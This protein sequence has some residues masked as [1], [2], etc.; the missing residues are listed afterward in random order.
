VAEI[1]FLDSDS[2]FRAGFYAMIVLSP[3]CGQAFCPR[4]LE[5]RATV[6]ALQ[7]A[8]QGPDQ[9]RPSIFESCCWLLSVKV[10]SGP[11]RRLGS[12]VIDTPNCSPL[13]LA[14]VFT[15]AFI[16][17]PSIMSYVAG[18]EGRMVWDGDWRC[19]RNALGSR[20]AELRWRREDSSDKLKTMNFGRD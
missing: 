5:P 12:V 6:A 16:A 13:V 8:G 2:T 17:C 15:I 14:N 1:K 11:C 9:K 20:D 10:V 4:R 19:V 3:A 7:A 18:A